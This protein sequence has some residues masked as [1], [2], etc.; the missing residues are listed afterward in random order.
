M[1]DPRDVGAV[2][3][4]LLTMEGHEGQTYVLTGPEA[5]TY[6][7]VA[8]QLSVATGR[9]VQFVDVP[10]MAARQGLVESGMPEWAV[11]H[12][13]RA[14]EII[15]HGGLKQTT[16]TVRALTG[17]EPRSFALWVREYAALF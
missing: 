5:I 16:D 10:A 11:E 3:A 17:H 15:R 13:A 7:Q 9:I 6:E 2:V 12:L 4:A 8:E 1:I 14:F